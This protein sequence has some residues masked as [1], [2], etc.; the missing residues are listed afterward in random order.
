MFH[1]FSNPHRDPMD[2]ARPGLNLKYLIL[3]SG[4]KPIAASLRRCA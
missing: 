4:G 3:F 1:F 2:A